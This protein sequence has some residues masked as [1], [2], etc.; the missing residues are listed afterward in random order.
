MNICL[1][2]CGGIS[3]CHLAAI[4]SMKNE[5]IN[6]LAVCDNVKEKAEAAA[7]K[8]GC[9]AYSDY[10]E[11]INSE[12]ADVIHICTPHYLHVDMAV[13]ALNK[14]I[15]VIMEKPCATSFEE[16]KKLEDACKVSSAQLGVC[17]QNRLNASTEFMK[18]VV[19]SGKYG[20]IVSARALF[21][22]KRDADYYAA[23]AWRGTKD[24]EC[25]GVLINQAI[26]THDL[27]T[28]LVGKETLSVDATVSNFH[29]KDEIEVEDTASIF[30]RFT[31]GTRAVYYATNAGGVNASP[32]I[33]INY[34]DKV[35]LRLEGDCV[36]LLDSEG[37]KL[38]FSE[39]EFK[40]N[41]VGK[42]EW[43]NSHNKLI[44]D[45][46][47]C[48]KTGRHFSIDVN[49]AK[50]AVAELLAAYESS[51]KNETVYLK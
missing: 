42:N 2:G 8:Y 15:N 37:L 4:D 7:L 34:P 27:L 10:D 41:N 38:L 36:Y 14:N 40:K 26:H 9:K 29:L 20:E 21:S 18:S 23:D 5:G 44:T 45:F 50:R 19:D 13:K 1:V 48:V 3:R 22:W 32:L 46:Y 49:E 43:G 31:D 51:E 25:G 6:L 39:K 17:F 24:K 47:D 35:T 16:I 30:L 12:A 28:Y 33:D 11:M